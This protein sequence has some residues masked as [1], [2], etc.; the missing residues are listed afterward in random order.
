MTYQTPWSLT[1]N[2]YMP[3][4]L[5]LIF[6]TER[7]GLSFWS[8]IMTFAVFFLPEIGFAWNKV[9]SYQVEVP[10]YFYFLVNS[11]TEANYRSYDNLPHSY[12]MLNLKN[13]YLILTHRLGGYLSYRFSL[14]PWGH[15]GEVKWLRVKWSSTDWPKL[16]VTDKSSGRPDDSTD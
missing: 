15:C 4:S 3:S 13:A 12:S 9:F 11:R 16:K 14:V 2:N 10:R 7:V 8:C 6:D 5:M 1:K